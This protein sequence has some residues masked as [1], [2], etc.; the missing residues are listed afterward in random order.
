[1]TRDLD[2]IARLWDKV[3]EFGAGFCLDTCHAFAAGWDLAT[4]GRDTQRLI[5]ERD[6][7]VARASVAAKDLA[8]LKKK[9]DDAQGHLIL[10]LRADG[11]RH[12]FGH[13]RHYCPTQP[14]LYE[15][16]RRIVAA[17]AER[18]PAYCVPPPGP[19]LRLDPRRCICWR[20]EP[21]R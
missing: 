14:A 9:Q 11:R 15:A 3:G 16:T 20:S 7:A 8:D 2:V 13:R 12:P 5:Q 1:M 21:Q 10:P 4:A 18:Y 6:Q 17:L 19:L